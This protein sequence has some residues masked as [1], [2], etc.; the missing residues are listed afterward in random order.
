MSGNGKES[1]N[2]EV[3]LKDEAATKSLAV[4]LARI[5]KPGD[6]IALWGDL[7]CGKTA[8][9]R[10][11]INALPG[12]DGKSVKEDVPSP[13][14]TIV[15]IYER[16][17]ADVWHLDLYRLES[18]EDVIELGLEDVWGEAIF[19]I[20]WPSRMASLLPE[21]RLDLTLK[22]DEECLTTGRMASI[23]AHG[24]WRERIAGVNF[25]AE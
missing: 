11:F 25:S 24:H 4:A 18:P 14:F 17:P 9:A 1:C 21:E 19:L 3:H 20:E 5:V 7:G 22:F 15:Q 8:F 2:I 6:V 10:A 13:T 12:P 16:S 23:D